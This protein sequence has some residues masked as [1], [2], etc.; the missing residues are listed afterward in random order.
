M[1]QYCGPPP[2]LPE[3]PESGW[4]PAEAQLKKAGM[5]TAQI[6]KAKMTYENTQKAA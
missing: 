3:P 4:A 5:T 2:P 6:S 1:E